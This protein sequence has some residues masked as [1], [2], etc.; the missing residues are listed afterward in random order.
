ML[1]GNLNTYT[2]LLCCKVAYSRYNVPWLL[3][4]RELQHS[5]A[6]ALS[7]PITPFLKFKQINAFK[8]NV[9]TYLITMFHKT[10]DIKISETGH[11]NYS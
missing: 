5:T 6:L 1:V 8:R 3:Q 9:V 4:H 7:P 2:E 11:R 10:A